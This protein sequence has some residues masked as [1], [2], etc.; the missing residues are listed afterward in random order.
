MATLDQSYWPTF[1]SAQILRKSDTEQVILGMKFVPSVTGVIDSVHL[2]LYKAGS[3]SGNLWVEIWT[4]AGGTPSIP[5]TQTGNDSGTVACSTITST[6]YSTPDEITFT[7]TSGPSLTASTPYWIV[8][9]GDYTPSSTVYVAWSLTINADPGYANGWLSSY[10]TSWA[11]NSTNYDM[12]FR[13]Y[14]V[15]ATTTTTSTSTSTSSTSTSSSST[16]TSTSTSST[17]STS[18]STSSTTTSV[19]FNIGDPIPEIIIM[20]EI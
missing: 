17:S 16:S 15:V 14:Y 3:P 13:E 7:F 11:T 6:S 20:K 2:P 9:C 12:G 18:S 10:G 19:L 4:D 1:G 8:L 5:N